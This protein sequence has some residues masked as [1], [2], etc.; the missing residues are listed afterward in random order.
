[1]AI[2]NNDAQEWEAR[3]PYCRSKLIIKY[4][5]AYYLDGGA[6]SHLGS[7]IN[8]T[9]GKEWNPGQEKNQGKRQF[10]Q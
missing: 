6:S 10:Q 5:T 7:I 9:T 4:T 1:M 2:V 3:C 8:P